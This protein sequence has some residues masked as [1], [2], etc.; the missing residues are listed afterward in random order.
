MLRFGLSFVLSVMFISAVSVAW[1]IIVQSLF[2]Y[3]FLNFLVFRFSFHPTLYFFYF[4]MFMIPSTAFYFIL[5]I[6]IDEE[7]KSYEPSPK[8]S[9]IEK[10]GEQLS[11]LFQ[12]FMTA[13][14]EYD[15]KQHL[16]DV[17]IYTKKRLWREI[18]D[19]SPYFVFAK[20]VSGRFF[21]IN[22]SLA[23]CYG[24]HPKELYMKR[25]SDFN[26]WSG[27]VN[28]FTADDQEVISTQTPKFNIVERITCAD[29]SIKILRTNKIPIRTWD[30]DEPAVLGMAEDI[31]DE[32]R[33]FTENGEFFSEIHCRNKWG[34][35]IER[36]KELAEKG[37]HD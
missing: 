7:I 26:V 25:D 15:E 35:V 5:R 34:V 14:A 6:R 23:D 21:I 19:I 13:I 32:F 28:G 18:A 1:I 4:I 31:T 24:V 20:D 33:C 30:N 9:S 8:Q 37:Y 2:K 27:E 10:T 22:K 12:Q 11:D 16:L 29:G 3:L 17:E 36:M